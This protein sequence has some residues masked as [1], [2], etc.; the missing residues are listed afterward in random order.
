[1]GRYQ[2][3]HSIENGAGERITFARRMPGRT[4]ERLEGDNVVAPGAGAPM[5][6]HCFCE[7]TFTVLEGRIGYQRGGGPERFGGPGDTIVF[8]AGE[9]H[10]FWNPGTDM[11]RCAASLEPADNVEYIL[12][13]LFGSAARNGGRPSLFDAAYL[14]RRYASEY[15]MTVVPA[16]VQRTLFPA[17]VVIGRLLGRYRRFADAPSPVPART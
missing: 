15:A 4:G 13:E 6:V 8:R 2:Y 3:P 5:H 7:E 12:T 1:M 17:A 9:P 11:L 16:L 14:S 10:R